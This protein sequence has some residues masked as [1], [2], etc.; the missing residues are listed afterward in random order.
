MV[1]VLCSHPPLHNAIRVAE[2]P[3]FASTS[4]AD[5]AE[6]LKGLAATSV[7]GQ[8]LQMAVA[9]RLAQK[10]ILARHLR[11]VL[12]ALQVLRELGVPRSKGEWVAALTRATGNLDHERYVLA[13]DSSEGVLDI[14][15]RTLH[16]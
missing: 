12:F 2:T 16:T 13:D 3:T 14:D 10:R 15:A 9:Y 7:E 11:R 8:R 1:R 6:Q 5:D 4:V